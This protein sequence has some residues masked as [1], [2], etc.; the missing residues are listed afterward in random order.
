LA[1]AVVFVRRAALALSSANI[2]AV[3]VATFICC[4][5]PQVYSW[6]PTAKTY[7]FSLFVLA[8]ICRVP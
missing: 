5:S 3:E 8:L 7:A 6:A 1:L 4:V 2:R